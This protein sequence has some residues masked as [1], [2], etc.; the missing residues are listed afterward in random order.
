MAILTE[1]YNRK[2]I[3][4]STKRTRCK[5]AKQKK[6][7]LLFKPQGLDANGV[8]FSSKFNNKSFRWIRYNKFRKN[9][10]RYNK[11]RKNKEAWF[12]DLWL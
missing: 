8:F 6:T 3:K 5:P 9:K 10:I 2:T 12:A 1:N 4:T 7:P 11:F